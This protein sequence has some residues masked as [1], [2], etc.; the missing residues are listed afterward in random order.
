M[1]LVL[2]LVCLAVGALAGEDYYS[3]LG[4]PRDADDSAIKRSYRKLSLKLHPG[5]ATPVSP[6]GNTTT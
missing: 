5:E 3:V 6:R 4:L 1:R 2:G